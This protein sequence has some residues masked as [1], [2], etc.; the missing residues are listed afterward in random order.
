M[1][2][3]ND[4]EIFMAEEKIRIFPELVPKTAWASNCRDLCSKSDWDWIRKETYKSAHYQCECCGIKNVRFDA[5]EIW[6]YDDKK[7]TQTLHSI[8]CVCEDCH[9]CFHLGFASVKGKLEKTQKHLAKVNGWSLEQTREFV[10]IV[11]EIWSQR[12]HHQWH[13]DLSLLDKVGVPYKK[14]SKEQRHQS[15]LK[16]SD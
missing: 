4:I 14:V 7:H 8:I 12:S 10:N 13:I 16:S 11:F 15:Y 2:D 3:N 9:M 6:H 1:N 5:H